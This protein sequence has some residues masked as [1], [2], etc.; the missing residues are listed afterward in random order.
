[1]G[2]DYNFLKSVKKM[3]KHCCI[4]V[5]HYAIYVYTIATAICFS[6]PY[7]VC[8]ILWMLDLIK[9]HKSLHVEIS[10][11]F[12]GAIILFLSVSDYQTTSKV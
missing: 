3:T 12:W 7:M 5:T 6:F 2:G 9:A 11:E 10:L 4:S 8:S 1:M